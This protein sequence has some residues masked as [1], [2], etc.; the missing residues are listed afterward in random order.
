MQAEHVNQCRNMDG[1]IPWIGVDIGMSMTMDTIVGIGPEG[2]I[3]LSHG[4]IVPGSHPGPWPKR[5]S[6]KRAKG[7]KGLETQ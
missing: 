5:A 1:E 4:L 3:L 6:P 2:E 7:P